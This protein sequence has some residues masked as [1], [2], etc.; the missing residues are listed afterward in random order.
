MP[1]PAF[2]QHDADSA[3]AALEARDLAKA[4]GGIQA[5]VDAGFT[6]QPRTLHALIGPNGAGKTTV[7]NLISGMFAPDRGSVTLGGARDHRACRRIARSRRDSA[8]S[9]Q[10]TNLFAGVSIDENV[11]LA[12][13]ARDPSHFNGWSDARSIERVTTRTAELI[14]FLGLT[15]IERADAG[16]L[17]YGGQRLLDMGLALASAP[18]VLLLDEPLAGLAAAERERVGDLIKRIS[19]D[20]PVLLVEHDIDRVF[21]LADRVTVMNDGRVLVDGTAEDARQSKA[22]QEIYIG[23]GA[24]A[25]AARPRGHA[26]QAQAPELL[27]LA[28][29]RRVLRQEPH[30]PR[31]VARRA[32]ERDRRAA[33]PQRRR[34][35][36]A[37]EDDHRYRSRPRPARSRWPATTLAARPP[38]EIARRGIGYVPQGRGSSPA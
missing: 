1:L 26:E 14:R 33:R 34:Q 36:D 4:F 25:L 22:V 20:I 18:R 19:A 6:V 3:G 38:A 11:R 24:A 27:A 12:V 17:S 21:A 9:F 15:G 8:R 29:C 30:R 2:L 28:R 23:T 13:Q 5:V 37:A 31:C 10:I 32:R 16:T 35:V 7:F